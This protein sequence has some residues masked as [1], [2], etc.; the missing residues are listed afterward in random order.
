[1]AFSAAV[2]PTIVHPVQT[3]KDGEKSI[4]EFEDKVAVVT[5]A[6]LGSSDMADAVVE[7]IHQAGGG[8]FSAYAVFNNPALMV[9]SGRLGRKVS[10]D[11]IPEVPVRGL[12]FNGVF[13]LSHCCK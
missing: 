2:F 5:G 9:Q 6:G 8:R 12:Q 13:H 10:W 1:M 4:S 3:N 7:E 11:P